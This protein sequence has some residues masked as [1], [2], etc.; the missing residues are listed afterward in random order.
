M[1]IVKGPEERRQ[2]IVDGAIRVFA[3]KGYEKTAISDIA[4]EIGISQGL[5]Y[6]YFPSKEAIY[7]AAL[8]QYA[9]YIVEQNL[10]RTQLAGK[11]LKEQILLMSGKTQEYS[12]TERDL[13]PLYD[14]FHK[15]GNRKLHD[16]LSLRVSEKLVPLIAQ[17]L[18]TA[19]ERGEVRL[20]D[21]D[22]A[23]YF[24]VFGQMGI[25]LDRT[26]PEETKAARI[27]SCLLELLGL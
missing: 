14:L 17:V 8:D 23:A 25:L 27:Q 12:T 7:D 5:C 6:R 11:T 9:A 13:K 10:A 1:R 24:F 2:E 3:R 26:L 18:R 20:S 16:Q 21:P 15:E 19:A 4:G 22:A